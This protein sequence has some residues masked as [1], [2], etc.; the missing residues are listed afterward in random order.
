MPS[1]EVVEA[2]N[3]EQGPEDPAFLVASFLP[4]SSL[5]CSSRGIKYPSLEEGG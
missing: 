1:A 5:V 3:K 2:G 4:E